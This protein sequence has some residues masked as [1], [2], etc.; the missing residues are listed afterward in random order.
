V[1]HLLDTSAVIAHYL[2]EAGAADVE[3]LLFM[4]SSSVALASPTWAELDKRLTELV[5]DPAEA[6]RVFRHYTRTLCSL[7]PVDEAAALAAIRIRRA[8]LA[9]LPVVDALIA[10]CAAAHGL[11]LVHRDKHMDDIPAAQVVTLRLPD[12]LTVNP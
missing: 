10:G 9:R 12:K 3:S 11:T 2:D 4:G 8:C 1:T 7:V 5:P 6:A